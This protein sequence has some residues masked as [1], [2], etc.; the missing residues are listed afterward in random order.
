MALKLCVWSPQNFW[1]RSY[2]FM[3]CLVVRIGWHWT[4]SRKE[5][6]L[7][8]C[9]LC[10]WVLSNIVYQHTHISFSFYELRSS[11][12][13]VSWLAYFIMK[14][15]EILKLPVYSWN[16]P[17]FQT[18]VEKLQSCTH[19]DSCDCKT[20]SSLQGLPWS[21]RFCRAFK[22]LSIARSPKVWTFP[23]PCLYWRLGTWLL[24]FYFMQYKDRDKDI[25]N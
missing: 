14:Q 6:W 1:P 5:N 2:P 3:S 7:K 20:L 11:L 4:L 19:D 21:N 23:W 22:Q 9:S 13:C 24:K 25:I 12:F 8:S 18:D 15:L 10:C 16:T 17:F